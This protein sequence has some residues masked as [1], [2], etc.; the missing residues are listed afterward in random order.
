MKWALVDGRRSQAQPGLTATCPGCGGEV[1]AKCGEL[2]QWHWAHRN[3][4]CDPWSEPESAWHLNWKNRFP[5]E[6]QERVIGDHRA[7][8]LT[9]KGVI[10]F[11]KSTI[12]TKT[13]CERE[14][15]YGRMVWVVDASGF[16]LERSSRLHW[17]N[18]MRDDPFYRKEHSLSFLDAI[19]EHRRYME[20][21]QAAV[22]EAWNAEPHFRWL[23][24]R[25]S[26]L[27]AKKTVFLD[28]GYDD[29]LQVKWTGRAGGYLICKR[30]MKDQFVAC[31]SR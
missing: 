8:V 15:F 30:I 10:E 16:N 17:K 9:P 21:H 26:W 19:C 29:L 20:L 27:A 22:D 4:E 25:K 23:W 18:F 6:W 5:A 11:Q 24:P 7:D 31:V 2:V 3:S 14:Q 13:I 28:R 12:S 1:L